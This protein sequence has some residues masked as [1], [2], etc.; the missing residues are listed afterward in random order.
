MKF[1]KQS[2]A[3]VIPFGPALLPADGV[4]LVTSLVS[5]LDHGTTGIFLH[6]NGGAGTI[7]HATVT[8]TTYDSYGNYL[9]TLDTTDTNT[10]GRLRVM[11]AAA[12]STLPIW[13]DFTVLPANVFDSL[14]SGS[15]DLK[16]DVDQIKT[17]T[18]TCGA[19]V[20][21][22]ASVGTAATSTAQTG[23]NYARIGAPAGA[24]VS[25]DVAAAKADTAAIKTKT[26]SLTF[27]VAGYVDAN[28]LK[29][30]G[31]T[32][33]ARDLGAS[34]LLSSGTG[35]GQVSLTS[36]AVTN[37]INLANPTGDSTGV[38]T[39]LSRIGGA[40]T[41]S[42][43]GVLVSAAGVQA[44]WDALTSALTTSGSIG[45]RLVDYLTG[46]IFARLGAPAGASHSADTAAVKVD[47]AAV[48]VQTD[49]LTFTVANQVDS[50]VLDWKSATA[51][52]M[53]GDAYARVGAPVGASISADVAGVPAA[54][55][56]K[57]DGVETSWTLRQAMRIML[58]SLAGKLSGAATTT[59]AVR[60]VGDSKDRISATV[61]AS[62]N[63]SAITYDKT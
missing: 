38:T 39:L 8:A 7:R 45:K 46:D 51:P 55:L 29:V 33:T 16:V 36:G 17:Q 30:G 2:T 49:K 10:L 41:I 34:V 18:V 20:T 62:G 59:V 63:R 22:L 14:V 12:A 21:V 4:T 11:F 26:D 47:T 3:A 56:D 44:I 48:K 53:T 24:S 54:L 19:G 1:L 37:V 35:T 32:Q 13:E 60:D 43:G 50:N 15:S 31:T 57:T 23:D 25:A 40:I 42:G 28:T 52:A 5:A 58:A 9:V 61:D 6:K 27:T